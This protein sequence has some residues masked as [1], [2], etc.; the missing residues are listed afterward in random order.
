MIKYNSKDIIIRAE[1]IADLENSDFI[2]DYEKLALLNECWTMLYQKIIDADDKTWIKTVPA[3]AGMALPA[4]LYQ[5]SALYIKG[6]KEQINKINSSEKYGYQI[7]GNHLYLSRNYIGAEIILEYYPVPQTLLLREKTTESKYTDSNILSARENIYLLNKDNR[8]Y[9][10]DYNDDSINYSLANFLD[11]NDTG[12]YRNGILLR[13]Y[14]NTFYFFSFLNMKTAV[15][16]YIPYIADDTIY[17]YDYDNKNIIDENY[18]IYMHKELGIKNNVRVIYG[19][20]SKTYVL[21]DTKIAVNDT[22]LD[23]PLVN[24]KAYAVNNSIYLISQQKQVL[25]INETGIELIKMKYIPEYFISE[26]KIVAFEPLHK[27]YYEEGFFDDTELDYPNNLFF[28][29]LSYMLA[30]SFKAKQGG[31]T[32]QLQQL[33]IQAENQFF[34]S[35]SRDSN[36]VYRIKNVNGVRAWF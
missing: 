9:L 27:K 4:D 36:D 13:D 32:D 6:S 25:R 3:R 24:F 21:Y 10:K 23:I 14:N 26:T 19:S 8:I 7:R 18:N 34:A 12:I 1:Q 22:E 33:E 11:I 16:P 5:L 17:F 30:L 2:S 31:E 35:I 29:I 28:V 20:E 15:V